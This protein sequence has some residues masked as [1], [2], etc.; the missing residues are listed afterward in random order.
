M[1]FGI[2]QKKDGGLYKY[3]YFALFAFPTWHKHVL[4]TKQLF[5]TEGAYQFKK[6]ITSAL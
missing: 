5:Y 1:A 3:L 6:T 4:L 2:L